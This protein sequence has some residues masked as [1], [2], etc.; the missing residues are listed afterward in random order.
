MLLRLR[1][2]NVAFWA[3]VRKELQVMLRYKGSLVALAVFAFLAPLGYY[4]QAVGFAG[5]NDQALAAFASRAGTTQIA[6]FIYLGWAVYL[7]ITQMLW[8]PGSSLRQERMEG[9][10]EM[11]FLTPVSRLTILIAPGVAQL[12][13]T[14][15]LFGSVGLI[16]RFVFGVQMSPLQLLAGLAVIVASIPALCSIGAIV[17]VAALRFRDSDGIIEALRGLIAV[18]CG[19]AYPIAVLPGWL[20]PISRALPPTQI[21]DQL[22]SA[23]LNTWS[24]DATVRALLLILVGVV[25]GWAA[26][27]LLRI[28][29]R[30]IR[31]TGRLGQF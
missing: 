2:E 24:G 26:L 25:L 28:S 18:L 27:I 12:L 13:P 14:T 15:V 22:R 4:A 21:I 30:S 31:Q 17:A 9:S 29:M 16:L 23:V 3:T 8:G 10:L 6:A 1:A 7:W 20:Q 11:V 19:V 5:N